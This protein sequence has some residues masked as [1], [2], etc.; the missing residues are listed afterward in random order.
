MTGSFWW[1]LL[2]NTL[3]GVAAAMLLA[4]LAPDHHADRR[5][6]AHRASGGLLREALRLLAAGRPPRR[7]QRAARTR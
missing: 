3:I 1:G 7:R 5:P 4:W 2:I 6:A